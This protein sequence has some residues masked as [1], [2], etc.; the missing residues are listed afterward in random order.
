[1]KYGKTVFRSRLE[2]GI[3]DK[4]LWTYQ[5]GPRVI[6]ISFHQREENTLS[7]FSLSTSSGKKMEFYSSV[8]SPIKIKEI[9]FLL[10]RFGTLG[11]SKWCG[12]LTL[13]QQCEFLLF[14]VGISWLHLHTSSSPLSLLWGS[15]GRTV[16]MT[17]NFWLLPDCVCPMGGLGRRSEK[18]EEPF[19]GASPSVPS[20]RGH[21]GM[22]MSFNCSHSFW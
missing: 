17:L 20:L 2:F 15:E 18:G 3:T 10:L 13:T 19:L 9:L 12:T 16:W 1:M 11:Q 21:P 4:G 5:I 7:P 8:P 6:K 22:A 14:G